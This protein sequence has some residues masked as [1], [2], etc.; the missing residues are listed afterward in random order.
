[1]LPPGYLE[2]KVHLNRQ[3]RFISVLLAAIMAAG[4]LLSGCGQKGPLFLPEDDNPDQQQK[5]GQ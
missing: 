4:L 5:S 3:L 1:M 2:N